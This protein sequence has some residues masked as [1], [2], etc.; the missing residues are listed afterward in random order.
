MRVLKL[1]LSKRKERLGM[2]E[3]GWSRYSW[4]TVDCLSWKLKIVREN[5]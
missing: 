1:V 4:P 2:R 3:A 5:L